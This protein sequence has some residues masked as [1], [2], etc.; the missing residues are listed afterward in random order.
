LKLVIIASIGFALVKDLQASGVPSPYDYFPAKNE[1]DLAFAAIHGNSGDVAKLIAEG[2][3]PNASS[4]DGIPILGWAYLAQSKAGF[5]ALLD[6]HANPEIAM[7]HRNLPPSVLELVINTCQGETYWF[8][9]LYD[10]GANPNYITDVPMGQTIIYPAIEY[11][12]DDLVRILVA[13]GADVNKRTAILADSPLM[14]SIEGGYR[15]KSS[16]ILLKAGADWTATKSNGK[17]FFDFLYIV[18]GRLEINRHPPW[19]EEYIEIVRWLTAH[20]A[21]IPD[22][23]ESQF[24]RLSK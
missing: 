8:E 14:A 23:L 21:K 5:K 15:L 16:L 19:T 24:L 22:A 9:Q 10:H 17:S 1:A 18:G 4:K 6:C 20:K 12:R 7:V 13:H 3:N 2:A 11:D